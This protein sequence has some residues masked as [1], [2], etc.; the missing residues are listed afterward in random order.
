MG[1]KSELEDNRVELDEM[2][3]TALIQWSNETSR[4]VKLV[5]EIKDKMAEEA[6]NSKMTNESS[7]YVSNFSPS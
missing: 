4:S 6:R 7:L 2:W 1:F 3:W 5:E